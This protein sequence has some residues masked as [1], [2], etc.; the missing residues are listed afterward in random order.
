MR[1]III[2]MLLVLAGCQWAAA[3]PNDSTAA[4]EIYNRYASRRGYT[5]KIKH[6]QGVSLVWITA[7]N[8]SKWKALKEELSPIDSDSLINQ[9]LG[10]VKQLVKQSD[11]TAATT[12]ISSTSRSISM[13]GSSDDTAGIV[14]LMRTMVPTGVSFDS[15]IAVTKTTVYRNGELVDER[16][17]VKTDDQLDSLR[18]QL[19]KRDIVKDAAKHFGTGHIMVANDDERTICLCFYSSDRDL[20]SLVLLATSLVGQMTSTR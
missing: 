4:R 20:L 1:R 12:K 11:D 9:S 17:N 2:A 13:V 10:L 5:A 6:S 16:T 19:L 14:E 8:D 7:K 15:A 18:L 3:A